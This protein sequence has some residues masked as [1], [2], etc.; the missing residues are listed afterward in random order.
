MGDRV[1][2]NGHGERAKSPAVGDV[3]GLDQVR[4]AVRGIRFGEVRVVIQ[5]GLI[6]QIDRLEKQRFR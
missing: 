2:S 5:D 3:L 1:V 6:V 4:E